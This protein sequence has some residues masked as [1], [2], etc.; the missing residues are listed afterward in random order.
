MALFQLDPSPTADHDDDSTINGAATPPETVVDFLEDLDPLKGPK[1][2]VPW[3]GN[4][5]IIRSA[6]SGQ[7]LTLIDGHVVLSSPGGRESKWACVQ[8]KGWLGFKNIAF[9]RYLGHDGKGYLCCS[10]PHH[11]DWE[12]FCIRQ[13]PDLAYILLMTHYKMLWHVGTKTEKGVEKLAKIGEN[14]DE[15]MLWE[16]VKV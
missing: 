7:V 13:T 3:P 10:V 6:V 16:F 12:N 14:M 5:Y 4:S 2:S 15:A 1:G 9:G 11:K 8:T